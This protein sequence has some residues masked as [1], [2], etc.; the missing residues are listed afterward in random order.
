MPAASPLRARHTLHAWLAVSV[1]VP[2]L[3]FIA[4]AWYDR[5]AI[6]RGAHERLLSA[7][8]A[9]A[10]HAEAV[11]QTAELTLSL[12]LDAVRGM[13]WQEI[14]TSE[15][16]HQF[17]VGL[18]KQLPHI[19]SI[20]F[21]DRDG[22][23]SA[24]SR[25]IP[26]PRFDQRD[27]E[28]YAAAKQGDYDLVVSAP[29]P[30]RIDGAAGF[31]VSRPR[32]TDGKFDG[33]AVVRL[34]GSS[35]SSLYRGVL[36]WPDSSSALL[37]RSDGAILA[38]Y[39]IV[40]EAGHHLAPSTATMQAAAIGKDTVYE[41]V[42]TNDDRP[43][44][45]AIHWLPGRP[46]MVVAAIDR[47]L[48]LEAW[49]FHLAL[50]AGFAL[51]AALALALC[52][53]VTVRRAEHD[54]L[55][56]EALVAETRR[57]QEAEA[58]LQQ[59]QKM[60]AL[61]R[62]TGGVAHDFNNLLTAVLASLELALRRVADPGV[63]RLLTI[64]SEAAQ[65]GAKLTAQMLTFARK[66]ALALEAIDGNDV[67]RGM[68]ELLRRSVGP[69]VRLNYQIDQDL[70][71]ILSDRVQLELAILNLVV[72]AHDAMPNGGD[73]TIAT[74]NLP[75]AE[76]LQFGLAERDQ[77][78]LSVADTGEGMTDA[79]RISAFE[80]FFTTKAP[81][82]G[83]GLGLSMVYGFA[84]QADGTVSIDSAPGEGTTV[85]L[86]LPRALDAPTLAKRV[87]K[88]LIERKPI[89]V[90]LVDDDAAV[91]EPTASM[92][93]ELGCTV[94]DV[95]NGASALALLREKHRCDV[96]LLDFAM[97]DMNGAEVAAVARGIRSDLP[98]VFITGFADPVLLEQ[99]QVLGA[100]VLAKPFRLEVLASTLTRAVR[101]EPRE[102]AEP[103]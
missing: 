7:T 49:Y 29:F 14:G 63:T 33:V 46:L 89:D 28:F 27:R 44:I 68:G 51:T 47:A 9:L 35:F 23:N 4:A 100:Q 22:F 95:D 66:Q 74:R 76:A 26:M 78:A 59:A 36:R 99:L 2:L 101:R 1:T 82:K 77:V 75:A 87:D 17:L 30:S 25:G 97:P 64:A 70:W 40:P 88:V 102:L 34:L 93:R 86:Y 32:M 3:L 72:N 5:N 31:T 50:F 10:A 16:V 73:I 85:T 20:F 38:R 92:L 24:S 42:S 71:P 43:K 37:L 90:L 61:G 67:V 62:L 53:T 45:A 8:D 52:A 11:M 84:R 81:G 56:L 94:T 57:R 18:D 48:L 55:S 98:I 79:I 21:I 96:L 6:M 91:R 83:T 60:D 103:G 58:A 12:Q 69:M 54:R 80:P 19:N 15:A 41:A 65:R 39:P 13:S